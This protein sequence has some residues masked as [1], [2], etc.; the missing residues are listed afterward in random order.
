MGLAP[1]CGPPGH[2]EGGA[3]LRTQAPATY[4][5]ALTIADP[6]KAPPRGVRTILFPPIAAARRG[7]WGGGPAR[8]GWDGGGAIGAWGPSATRLDPWTPGIL[9]PPTGRS[10]LTRAER[11]TAS[12]SSGAAP[13]WRAGARPLPVWPPWFY[14]MSACSRARAHR[15]GPV[16]G[17]CAPPCT[18]GPTLRNLAE[19]PAEGKACGVPGGGGRAR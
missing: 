17:T 5:P 14:R 15:G 4:V 9:D 8:P 12:G 18:R 1:N 7:F 6:P 13:Q 19:R 10:P 3:A 16:E 2:P 11:I